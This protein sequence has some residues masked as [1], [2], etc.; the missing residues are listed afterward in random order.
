MNDEKKKQHAMLSFALFGGM[1]LS[2]KPGARAANRT[3]DARSTQK[4]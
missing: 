3:Q 4:K 1:L 2:G